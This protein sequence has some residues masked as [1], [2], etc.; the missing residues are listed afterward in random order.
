MKASFGKL[1]S[2]SSKTS[3]VT[4]VKTLKPDLPGDFQTNAP[5][6]PLLGSRCPA[7]KHFCWRLHSTGV[8]CLLL[9]QPPQVQFLAFPKNFRGKIIDVA[10]VNQRRWLEE[11]GQQLE[12]VDQVVSQCYKYV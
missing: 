5:L 1:G 11:S 4:E 8:A 10:E 9:A 12:N 2:G 7:K 6:Y 3:N